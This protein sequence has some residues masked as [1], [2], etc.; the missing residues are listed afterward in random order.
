MNSKITAVIFKEGLYQMTPTLQNT[1]ET[2]NDAARYS[3]PN[4]DGFEIFFFE[5]DFLA[6]R[7][8]WKAKHFDVIVLLYD[9]ERYKKIY[10]EEK[11]PFGEYL[12]EIFPNICEI[13]DPIFKRSVILPIVSSPE[14]I[15]KEIIDMFWLNIRYNNGFEPGMFSI[16]TPCYNTPKFSLYRLYD[17]IKAQTY[18]HWEW[19][20]LDDSIDDSVMS[21]LNEVRDFRIRV[22]KNPYNSGNIGYNKRLLGLTALGSYIVEVDH[23]DELLPE[24]LEELGKA[25][26]K[27]PDAGFVYTNAFEFVGD[28][29]VQDYGPGWAFGQGSEF[30]QEYKGLAFKVNKAPYINEVSIRHIVGIPNHCRAWRHSVYNSLNGHNPTFSIADDYEL[31][32]RTFLH[33]KIAYIEK[34]LYVQHREDSTTQDSRIKEIQRCV[35]LIREKFDSEIHNRILELG[36][37]DTVWDE[38]EKRANISDCTK[39][40]E[41]VMCYVIKNQQS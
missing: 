27:Y 14:R 7:K 26:L 28:K 1:L 15:G 36:Y 25:F 4:E 3:F 11:V 18:K 9:E 17:S 12:K 16:I 19:Y 21:F 31:V 13:G 29:L 6:H 5:D 37:E 23:D 33:T 22:I 10:N 41:N 20:I 30:T 39:L 8:L 40:K 32:V 38:K 2:I 34:A 24:C 35:S